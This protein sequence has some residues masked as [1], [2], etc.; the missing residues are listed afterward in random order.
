MTKR[1]A[2]VSRTG[3]KKSGMIFAIPPTLCPILRHL[4]PN[5]H[6]PMRASSFDRSTSFR[7][8]SRQEG[9]PLTLIR[10][11]LTFHDG[12]AFFPPGP[13]RMTV[14]S[15]SASFGYCSFTV[16]FRMMS[17]LVGSV[18]GVMARSFSSSS[19]FRGATDFQCTSTSLSASS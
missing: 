12:P 15:F 3:E 10:T 7:I 16:R 6:L 13:I 4:L 8:F 18:T 5:A 1:W 11:F 9:M 17:P 2:L 19:F 14:S